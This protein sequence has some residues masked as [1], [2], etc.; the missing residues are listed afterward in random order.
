MFEKKSKHKPNLN[1]I[2]QILSNEVE[3]YNRDTFQNL[4]LRINN[5]EKKI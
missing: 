4:N 2:N 5:C 3:F 1:L